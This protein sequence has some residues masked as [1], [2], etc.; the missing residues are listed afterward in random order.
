M[1]KITWKDFKEIK[2]RVSTILSVDEFPEARKPVYNLMVLFGEQIGIKK[3]SAQITQYYLKKQLIGK[4]VI[5]VVNFLDKQIG[6][7][8]SQYLITGFYDHQGYVILTVPDKKTNN[9]N[10]LVSPFYLN[11]KQG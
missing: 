6:S 8:M 5:G 2:L 1:D 10:K 11:G 3:S 7:L 4:Q 9:G